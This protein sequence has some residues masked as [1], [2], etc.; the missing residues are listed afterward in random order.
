MPEEPGRSGRD[1]RRMRRPRPR[2]KGASR[3]R[4]Q[5]LASKGR[6]KGRREARTARLWHP[7]WGQAP[8]GARGQ[9]PP[10]QGLRRVQRPVQGECRARPARRVRPPPAPTASGRSPPWGQAPL[11]ADRVALLACLSPRSLGSLPCTGCSVHSPRSLRSRSRAARAVRP[12]RNSRFL[13]CAGGASRPSPTRSSPFQAPAFPLPPSARK[14]RP[15]RSDGPSHAAVADSLPLPYARVRFSARPATPRNT[16]IALV[17][18][19]TA[20]NEPAVPASKSL[21]VVRYL[22]GGVSTPS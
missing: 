16:S 9:A 11:R 3:A 20:P 6:A 10:R 15:I 8:Q 2:A 4:G 5:A 12:L 1:G 19:G 22:P 18:S 17:G 21:A 13:S 7:P 14:A